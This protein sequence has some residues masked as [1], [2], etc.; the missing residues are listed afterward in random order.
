MQIRISKLAQAVTA[1]ALL[2]GA[3]SLPAA[4]TEQ[5]RYTHHRIVHR[6]HY[7]AHNNDLIVRKRVYPVPVAVAPDAFH[8]GPATIITAPVAIAGTIVSLPF[9]LVEVVFPPVT[10]DPRVVVG[11][12]VHFAGQIAE[13]PFYAVN[14]AFGVQPAYY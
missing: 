11:A 14:H 5:Y 10:N 3:Y 12:P 9:R 13:F 6:A 1:A 2:A 8:N 7:L 4:A